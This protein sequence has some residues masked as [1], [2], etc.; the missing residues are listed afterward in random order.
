[1][2]NKLLQG[3]LALSAAAA[4]C[5]G[6]PAVKAS[7]ETDISTEFDRA[8]DPACVTVDYEN[9]EIIIS[10]NYEWYKNQGFKKD[11]QIL[12][13]AATVKTTKGVSKLTASNWEVYDYEY[14]PTIL[15]DMS[16]D[17]KLEYY[18]KVLSEEEREQ[19]DEILEKN[20]YL[21]KDVRID[22]SSLNR[23]KDNYVQ[24]K[25]SL[26]NEPLTIKIPAVNSDLKA[27][28]NAV[29][30]TVSF[31]TKK[32]KETDVDEAEME[33]RTQYSGWQPFVTEEE[34]IISLT[35]YRQRGATLYLRTKA[36][37]DITLT[38]DYEDDTLDIIDASGNNVTV[39]SAGTFPGIELKV[40]VSKLANA[41]KVTV[42]YIKGNITIPK[43]SS[44]RITKASAAELDHDW[45]NAENKTILSI[46]TSEE[47][48]D[49][50]T[51]GGSLEVVRPATGTNAAS[52]IG[53]LS[54]NPKEIVYAVTEGEEG[55][56]AS[57]AATSVTDSQV[58]S[59]IHD[60]DGMIIDE[61]YVEVEELTKDSKTG[62][63]TLVLTNTGSDIYEVYIQASDNIPAASTAASKKIAAATE[64]KPKQT[65][66]ITKLAKGMKVFIRKAGNKTYGTWTTDYVCF[67][68]ITLADEE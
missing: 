20:E 23:T 65:L 61:I 40:S 39:L 21:D 38:S 8:F 1:M 58:A 45:K 48:Q 13:S 33:Y 66:K 60:E 9:Q 62:K 30:G 36:S 16:E 31:T 59:I 2:G 56:E 53:Y 15:D 12:F 26:Y 46:N 19:L 44:Y 5:L 27:K 49:I 50:K 18:N 63:Y 41:P 34:D 57:N 4:I 54:F 32:G 67:G 35:K 47:L 43:G 37:E 42:D 7:A 64:K 68:K 55:Y 28:F 6:S 24:I 14:T 3:F 52:K 29:D 10:Q 51:E 25:G 22:I 17:L 11:L